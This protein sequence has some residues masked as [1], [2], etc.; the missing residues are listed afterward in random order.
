MSGPWD[1]Y[2]APEQG[3]WARYAPEK[4]RGLVSRIVN[5]LPDRMVG[6]G[7]MGM[8]TSAAVSGTNDALE[9]GAY[10]AGGRVT[11]ATGSPALG[12]AA[13]VAV[14]AI[15][16]ALGGGTGSMV[17]SGVKP[18]LRS[19]AEWMMRSALKPSVPDML[20]GKGPRAINTLLER[21]ENVSRGGITSMARDKAKVAGQVLRELDNA[22]T[23]LPGA[24]PA[25][26]SKTAAGA[27]VLKE[28]ARIDDANYAGTASDARAQAQKV[29]DDFQKNAS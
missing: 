12:T 3:P 25:T 11:D 9:R 19:G 23:Q 7:P 27:P 15:P 4:P 24:P 18:A 5:A 14:Q 10:E 22:S 8:L 26:V 1:K 29:F 16:M 20:S 17:G 6:G 13:N 21:G 28:V 2:A